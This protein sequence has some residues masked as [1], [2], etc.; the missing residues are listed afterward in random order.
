MD[1]KEQFRRLAKIMTEIEEATIR[2]AAVD[3]AGLPLSQVDLILRQHRISP[4]GEEVIV[5]MLAQSDKI[6]VDS[7][8]TMLIPMK[9]V[10]DV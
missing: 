9:V 6:T 10:I 1:I 2:M 8:S 5:A 3:L 4:K 7:S